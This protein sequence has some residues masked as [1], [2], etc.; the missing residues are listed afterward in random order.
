MGRELRPNETWGVIRPV[1]A[2]YPMLPAHHI[3]CKLYHGPFQ[4][5]LWCVLT[6]AYP[7]PN[8]LLGFCYSS[9]PRRSQYL[10]FR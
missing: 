7:T 9:F 4:L 3:Q 6:Q 2:W 5:Y 1:N 10:S 8:L